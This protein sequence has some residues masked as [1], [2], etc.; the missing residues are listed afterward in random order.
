MNTIAETETLSDS[1]DSDL[2]SN[3]E[4]LNWVD[5]LCMDDIIDIECRIQEY[6]I[7]WIAANPLSLAS[8][9]VEK[10]LSTD[11]AI[12]LFDEWLEAEICDDSEENY[13][14]VYEW[15]KQTVSQMNLRNAPVFYVPSFDSVSSRVQRL[16]DA[17]NPEQRTQAWYDSR[18]NLL[19]ASNLWKAL[20]TEA[21]RNSLIYEKCRPYTMFVEEC[22][23]H[24]NLSVENTMHWG[25]KY[26][27]VSIALY[28]KRTQSHIQNYGCIVHKEHAFL[29]ASP[30]GIVSSSIGDFSVGRMVEIKNIVNRE[31]TGIPLDHYWIQMQIQMEVCDLE[32]CDF[33]E[34]RFKEF[35]DEAAYL[36]STIE[37]KGILLRFVQRQTLDDLCSVDRIMLDPFYEYAPIGL[38]NDS[39]WIQ[40]CREKHAP[41]YVLAHTVYWY[42]DQ[43]SCVLVRRNRDWFQAALP[44][45]REVWDTVL[46]ERETGYEHRAPNKRKNPVSKNVE[47]GG[48]TI[49]M[50]VLSGGL[51]LVKLD[52]EGV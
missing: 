35:V 34:T 27:S 47:S 9:H 2:D 15:T 32:E 52:A 49:N 24:G 45:I 46:Q 51:C 25:H 39:E 44:K 7:E 29:G 17:P 43:Y 11:L 41:K 23:R 4:T 19:T 42:L 8:S 5:E 13:Q 1:S 16:N 18:Y 38:T 48:Y 28:E 14:F 3:P 33:V 30:D 22:S 40:E 36:E 50:P 12:H 21:Q 37:D 31:I 20:G 10:T 26:E 6:A